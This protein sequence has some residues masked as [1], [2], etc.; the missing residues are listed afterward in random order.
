MGIS[1]TSQISLDSNPNDCFVSDNI[2]IVSQYD[3]QDEKQ[4]EFFNQIYNDSGFGDYALERDDTLKRRSV[5]EEG[6]VAQ[7]VKRMSDV[8]LT[9]G[10]LTV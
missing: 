10:K 1:K 6:K 7:L 2:E 9:N 3:S 4:E 5:D 8:N